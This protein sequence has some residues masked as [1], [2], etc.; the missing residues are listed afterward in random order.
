[1]AWTTPGTA[2][3][4]DVLTA[5]F[6]NSN[7][8]D[9]SIELAPFFDSRVGYTA[10]LLQSTTVTKSLTFC[11]YLKVGRFVTVEFELVVTAGTAGVGGNQI[12]ISVPFTPATYS[13]VFTS[14]GT[15]SLYDASSLNVYPGLINYFDSTYVTLVTSRSVV[16]NGTQYLGVT[17]FTAGLAAGDYIS[18]SF[19]YT[20][21]S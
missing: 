10:T 2:V 7:V 6:W 8:R 15:C 20:S 21:A 19:T 4:G 13:N 12:K 3:A 18:G 1:M 16:V 17:D 14:I 11:R 9:N 5:A